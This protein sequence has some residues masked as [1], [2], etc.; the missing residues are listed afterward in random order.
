M[1]VNPV[2]I[3]AALSVWVLVIITSISLYLWHWLHNPRVVTIDDGI[4]VIEKGATLYSVATDLQQQDMLRWPM[5]WVAYGRL[6]K[7]QTIQAGEYTLARL[8][9]PASLLQRFQTAE[10]IQYQV[11]LVEGRTFRDFVATLHR[12]EKLRKVIVGETYEE[13]AEQLDMEPSSL[14]GSFFPDTY[15]FVKGDTDRAILL[16]AHKR[17]QEIMDTE[18]QSREADL[19]Y[20]SPYEALIMASIIEKETGVGGER[21]EIA[22][23]FV[24]RLNKRM[25][26]QTDPTVI[27][28]L[29]ANYDGNLRRADLKNPTPYNTY[30]IF[31]LP[32]TPIA[33]PGREAIYAALHPAPGDTLYFVA[34]GDGSHYF[35]TTLAEHEAAVRRFQKKRRSDYRSSPPSVPVAEQPDEGAEHE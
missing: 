1:S 19:P 15:H 8:E 3:L 5:V 4:F 16:R 17:M 21:G 35:S 29:G 23:V 27:Y 10:H 31:G 33:M 34:K 2:R 7:L 26:L 14:E 32:P 28:G 22:G 11:T 6:M 25:R 30:T 18:W 13:F 9:S 24:R 12:H 20:D